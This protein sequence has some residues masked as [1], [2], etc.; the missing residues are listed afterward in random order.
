[1]QVVCPKC[2]TKNRVPDERLTHDPLCGRCGA[3]LMALAPV[4]L[5]DPVFARYIEGAG[6]PVL[7][8]FWADWCP[9][10]KMLAPQFAAAAAQAPHVRFM[11]VDTEAAPEASRRCGI[12]SIPTLVLFH[13]GREIARRSGALSAADISAWLSHALSS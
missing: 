4:A 3:P 12:R 9:P 2:G 6:M 11:K 13:H 8:D 1:M 10:C 5:D 7:V